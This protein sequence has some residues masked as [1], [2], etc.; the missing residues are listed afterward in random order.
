[1]ETIA[2]ALQVPVTS[3]LDERGLRWA[4]VALVLRGA[5]AAS[6]EL[7]FIRRAVRAGDP[8]SGH[9]A[10]PGGRRD[11]EDDS[12]EVTARRETLEELALNLGDAR[13][14][15]RL[16][17]LRPR[18]AHLPRIAVRPYVYA[19]PDDGALVPNDEVQSTFWVALQALRQNDL[20]AE[21]AVERDGVTMR[22]PAYRIGDDVVW[23]M[24]ERFVTQL[25]DRL[26]D[27]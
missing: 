1:V 14:L 26:R 15:G 13:L 18:S 16:D 6:A 5:D 21:H 7:L 22:F 25:L 12:L 8:W 19:I 24:T 2:R 10:F 23:G 20:R 11:P 4:A 27:A 3:E 9:V 17:D